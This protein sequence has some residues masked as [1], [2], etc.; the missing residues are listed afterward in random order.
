MQINRMIASPVPYRP[1]RNLMK[2]LREQLVLTEQAAPSL[3]F[4]GGRCRQRRFANSL[5]ADTGSAATR[6]RLD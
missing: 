3:A 4:S 5:A 1:G 2:P 6:M